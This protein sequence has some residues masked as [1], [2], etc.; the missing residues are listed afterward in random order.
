M[1]ETAP[2]LLTFA[3]VVTRV[4][5]RTEGRLDYV[6]AVK[7]APGHPDYDEEYGDDQGY[8]TCRYVNEDGSP[9]C[10]VGVAFAE[11]IAAAGITFGAARNTDG[12]LAL[13]RYE[14]TDLP[15][16]AKAISFLFNL[17]NAQD[18]GATWGEAIT[19]AK[20]AADRRDRDDTRPAGDP[21][22]AL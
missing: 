21:Y 7:L 2:A 22:E 16:T 5:Q 12:I 1:T 3:D 15:L 9:S 6:N 20:E 10:I 4:E 14:L 13:L 11:E 8:A 18:N 19:T 17:Q